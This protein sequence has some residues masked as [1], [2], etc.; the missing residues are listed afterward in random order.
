MF[1]F[2]FI[3]ARKANCKSRLFNFFFF[4]WHV[5]LLQ[6]KTLFFEWCISWPDFVQY[7]LNFKATKTNFIVNKWCIKFY[8]RH[9]TSWTFMP[10][11]HKVW[12]VGVWSEEW[13]IRDCIAHSYIMFY[14]VAHVPKM[15]DFNFVVVLRFILLPFQTYT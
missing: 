14:Y 13:S 15:R 11:K 12:E 8:Y 9:F 6:N 2:C 7:W 1:F 4:F 3:S 10:L 5:S